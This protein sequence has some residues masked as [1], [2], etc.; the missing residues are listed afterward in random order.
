MILLNLVVAVIV[1]AYQ[2]QQSQR[3]RPVDGWRQLRDGIFRRLKPM[4]KYQKGPKGESRFVGE[5]AAAADDGAPSK[6]YYDEADNE[7]LYG[8]L[9]DM[10]DWH[11]PAAALVELSVD[12]LYNGRNGPAGQPV[13]VGLRQ[14]GLTRENAEFIFRR[15][16]WCTRWQD[17]P[18]AEPEF[19]DILR[20]LQRQVRILTE[21]HLLA[22]QKLDSVMAGQTM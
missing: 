11:D 22:Q 20:E 21:A 13:F 8:W 16:A 10:M 15:F 4:R 5:G 9:R 2:V 6:H 3:T 17:P 14:Q 12:D 1:E 18:P 7:T 19:V